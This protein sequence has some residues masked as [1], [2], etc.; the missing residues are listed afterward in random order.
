[1]NDL[2]PSP[3]P[4]PA[5]T[6]LDAL[7]WAGAAGVGEQIVRATRARRRQRLVRRAAGAAALVAMVAL[8]AFALRPREM[9]RDA[10]PSVVTRSVETRTLA[11]GSVVELRPGAALDVEF[12]A[13]ERRVTLRAGE[14]HFAVQKDA[15]RPFVVVASSVRVRAVGTAFAVDLGASAVEVF[16]TEG[17]VAVAPAETSAPS[18]LVDAGR[19][20]VVTLADTAAPQVEAVTAADLS[21]RLAWR[22][23][24]LEFTGTALA[25]VITL[26]NRHAAAPL[27][28]DPGL[29]TLRLSGT[30][31]A[32]DTETLLLLLRNEFGLVAERRADGVLEI[33]R[34]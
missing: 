16:V 22:V 29:G 34:P 6:A 30:I 18:A 27:V 14:A 20:A 8:G 4:A 11:D 12:S 2:P 9:A 17:T 33:R 1:M 3:R 21:A 19:R 31:R 24:L 7:A 26:F 15:S 28:L 13:G 25:E 32:D 5:E 23:P 10:A